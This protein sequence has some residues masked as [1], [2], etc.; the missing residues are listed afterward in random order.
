M[1]KFDSIL[2]IQYGYMEYGKCSA[3]PR[4]VLYTVYIHIG[5]ILGKVLYG[6]F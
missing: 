6:N 1:Q 5:I 3:R 4:Y 2:S